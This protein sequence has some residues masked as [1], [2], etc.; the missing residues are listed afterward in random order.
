MTITLAFNLKLGAVRGVRLKGWQL[1]NS[2]LEIKSL[3]EDNHWLESVSLE[4][5]K[6]RSP[7]PGSTE[8]KF[9][10]RLAATVLNVPRTDWQPAGNAQPGAKMPQKPGFSTAKQD[11]Y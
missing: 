9:S 2:F 6:L 7:G 4:G 8:V 11:L 3:W 10:L 5:T 1:A